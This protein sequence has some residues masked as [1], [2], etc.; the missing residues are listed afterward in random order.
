M[1]A[2][3]VGRKGVILGRAKLAAGGWNYGVFFQGDSY[4]L[5]HASLKPTG[6]VFERGEIYSGGVAKV[7]VDEFGTGTVGST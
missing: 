3:F 7:S 5:P 1:P 4:Y 6:V 2:E